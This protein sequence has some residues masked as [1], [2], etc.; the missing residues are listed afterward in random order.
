MR[1]HLEEIL[2]VRKW[3]RELLLKVLEETTFDPAQRNAFHNF[4][5]Q[6]ML[7]AAFNCISILGPVSFKNPKPVGTLAREL[8]D[9]NWAKLYNA[10]QKE[11]EERYDF[12]NGRQILIEA[13]KT[14]NVEQRDHLERLYR[15]PMNAV[16]DND[17]YSLNLTPM[18][19]WLPDDLSR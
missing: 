1:S 7:R 5:A 9:K 19:S 11:T 18:V 17:V 4:E 10:F 15:L 3:N 14:M 13:V 2:A 8:M 16:M 12:I 6:Q